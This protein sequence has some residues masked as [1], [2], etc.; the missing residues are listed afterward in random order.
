MCDVCEDS[1]H[2][3]L[4]LQTLECNKLTYLRLLLESRL[5]VVNLSDGMPEANETHRV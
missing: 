2:T 4:I 5:S 1:I 3:L